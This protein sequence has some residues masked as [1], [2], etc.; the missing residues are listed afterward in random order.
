MALVNGTWV[1]IGETHML[2]GTWLLRPHWMEG[3]VPIMTKL[4]APAVVCKAPEEFFQARLNSLSL[5]LLWSGGDSWWLKNMSD[6]LRSEGK[7]RA[8]TKFI[9]RFGQINRANVPLIEPTQDNVERMLTT[10]CFGQCHKNYWKVTATTITSDLSA[11]GFQRYLGFTTWAT[12]LISGLGTELMVGRQ[13]LKFGATNATLVEQFWHA[14]QF[15][16]PLFA[17]IS[18]GAAI[19]GALVVLPTVSCDRT[20]VEVWIS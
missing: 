20:D 6:A 7:S 4:V 13:L 19:Y 5:V 14:A 1:R 12:V 3:E 18:L 16:F 8:L 2:L 10:A 9:Q 11:I 17:T 15:T